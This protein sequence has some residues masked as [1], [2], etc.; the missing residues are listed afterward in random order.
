MFVFPKL[1]FL[2][3]AFWK[4]CFIGKQTKWSFKFPKMKVW[5]FRDFYVFRKLWA[6]FFKVIGLFLMKNNFCSITRSLLKSFSFQTNFNLSV[7]VTN[8]FFHR[9]FV[10][11]QIKWTVYLPKIENFEL[12][13]SQSYS[14]LV[15]F[16]M[17]KNFCWNFC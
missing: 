4:C 16:R 14:L 6:V 12:F 11:K 1:F 13:S 2:P 15:F 8:P 9:F 3:V 5:D 17:K 7:T 10:R